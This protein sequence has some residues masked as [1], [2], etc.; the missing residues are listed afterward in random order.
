M[1]GMVDVALGGT[2]KDSYISHSLMVMSV[3]TF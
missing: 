2:G 1:G 3:G